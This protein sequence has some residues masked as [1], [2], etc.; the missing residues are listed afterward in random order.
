LNVTAEDKKTGK[1]NQ[2]TI[3]NDTGRLSQEEIANMV[4]D[5]ERF[6]EQ[7]KAHASKIA[8]KNGLEGYAYNM[9]NSMSQ[10]EGKI[11]AE[12]K[13]A[14][15]DAVQGVINWLDNNQEESKETYEAK[16][17]ELEGICNPILQKMYQGGGGGGMPGGMPGG[18]G[19]GMPGGMGGAAAPD[20]EASAGPK[21]EEVD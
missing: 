17:K 15:D 10:A 12:D 19:G 18:M 11:P 14:I 16:Q 6:A 5:A 7:D 9:K 8:A 2:I 3:T 13:K 4:S 1:K 20:A 21:V